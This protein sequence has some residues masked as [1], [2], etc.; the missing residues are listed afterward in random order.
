MVQWTCA[1]CCLAAQCT[2][3]KK[4]STTVWLVTEVD[5]SQDEPGPEA[6]EVAAVEVAADACVQTRTQRRREQR[7]KRK[8]DAAQIIAA[9][10]WTK[11]KDTVRPEC[12]DHWHAIRPPLGVVVNLD[13]AVQK[14]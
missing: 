5:L 9:A 7:R 14:S 8:A 13:I 4:Y 3:C 1:M 6:V 10:P 2:Q 11:T 12:G